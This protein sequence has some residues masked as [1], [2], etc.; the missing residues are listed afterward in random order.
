MEVIWLSCYFL[1]AVLGLI[2]CVVPIIPGPILSFVGLLFLLPTKHAP[3]WT[4]LI[5]FGGA[6]VVVTVLDYFVSVWGA[7]KFRASKAGAWGCFIGSIIGLFFLPVGLIAG[8]F[9]GAFLGELLSGR[10]SEDAARSGLGALVGFLAG[11]FVKILLA[12]AVLA[13]F[14]C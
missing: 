7:K 6:A 11:T 9:F 13:W 3:S 12:G 14:F 8:P 1:F 10:T 4:M 5:L 2:G